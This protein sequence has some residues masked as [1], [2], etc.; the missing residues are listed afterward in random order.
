M[1]NF[2][3]HQEVKASVLYLINLVR[4][5]HFRIHNNLVLSMEV[6]INDSLPG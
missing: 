1:C 3:E 5:F 6:K 2:H 4:V